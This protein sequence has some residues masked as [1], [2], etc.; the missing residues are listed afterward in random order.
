[1]DNLLGENLK[2]HA[3]VHL[4]TQIICKEV[5]PRPTQS[6]PFAFDKIT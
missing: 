6:T 5:T 4:G 2:I 3:T 1:M